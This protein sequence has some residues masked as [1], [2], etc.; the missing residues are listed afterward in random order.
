MFCFVLVLVV[1]NLYCHREEF[2]AKADRV[3]IFFCICR[4]GTNEI[5]NFYQS[6]EILCEIIGAG[7]VN[8]QRTKRALLN[9]SVD[10][11]AK[12]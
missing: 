1:C 7:R 2:V 6:L 8:L 11:K 10:V 12:S 3:F 9:N 4:D 5:L